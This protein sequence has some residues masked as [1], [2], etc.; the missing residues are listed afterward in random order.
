MAKNWI[1]KKQLAQLVD[2][3]SF[4]KNEFILDE[5]QESGSYRYSC[6]RKDSGIHLTISLW[7]NSIQDKTEG[8]KVSL[9]DENG[10]ITCTDFYRPEGDSLI[11]VMRNV[12]K[13]PH[14]KEHME[15]IK[16]IRYLEKENF[17]IE[18]EKRRLQNEN[19]D[20]KNKLKKARDITSLEKKIEKL[21]EE[22]RQLKKDIKECQK[23]TVVTHIKNE[24]GAGRH[25]SPERAEAVNRLKQL[26][27]EDVSQEEIM[28]K[29][30]ISKRTYYRYKKE[31]EQ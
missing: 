4:K 13:E 1:T 6:L 16:D 29:L 24:R 26:I 9:S 25:K 11:H 19:E 10:I 17:A 7:Y 8:Y 15:A 20:L 3:Y 12:P 23:L 18:G 28:K 22:N 21:S 2:A 5:G 27:A 31:L 14:S 30:K